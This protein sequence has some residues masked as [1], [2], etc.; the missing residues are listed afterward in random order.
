MEKEEKRTNEGVKEPA[1]KARKP[2]KSKRLVHIDEFFIGKDIRP[3]TRAAIKMRLDKDVFK[4]E[5][6]WKELLK[7]YL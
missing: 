3:E 1:K 5:D 4:S 6:E 7:E 2:E